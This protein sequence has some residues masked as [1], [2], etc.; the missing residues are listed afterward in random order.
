MVFA[1]PFEGLVLG[2]GMFFGILLSSFTKRMLKKKSGEKFIFDTIDFVLGA[3]IFYFI[4][5]GK[6]FQE[7]L[8][9]I[10][11]TFFLHRLSNIVAFK[12]K[13]KEIPW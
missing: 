6:I 11:I 9:I 2:T 12:L 3:Q 13:L 5:F 4:V 7:L 8:L 10:I 1:V